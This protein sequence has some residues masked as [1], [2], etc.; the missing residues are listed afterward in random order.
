[1][2]PAV[3]AACTKNRF[4]VYVYRYLSVLTPLQTKG[5]QRAPQRDPQ[6]VQGHPKGAKGTQREP[7]APQ[8]KPNGTP[9]GAKPARKGAKG[10]PRAHQNEPRAPIK[11]PKE[12]QGHPK[13][14]KEVPKSPQRK[15]K[16]HQRHSRE[17]KPKGRDLYFKLPINRPSGRYVIVKCMYNMLYKC[18]IC[19]IHV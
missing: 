4:V 12:A 8:R 2:V 7:R 1:M 3:P 18:I 11:E 15:P 14:A 5:S 19:R 13:G 9:K 6:G 17:G 16:A 10:S